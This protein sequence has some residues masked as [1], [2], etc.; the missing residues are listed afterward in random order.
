ML[1][2][3]LV[4]ALLGMCAS[5]ALAG[6]IT[7]NAPAPLP[8]N[9]GDT[10]MDARYRLSQTN[11]DQVIATSSNVT[12][13]TI[14]ETKNLGTANVLNGIEWSLQMQYTA[15]SGYVFTLSREGAVPP[16]NVSVVQWTAPYVY[17]QNPPV[18][19]LRNFNSIHLYCAAYAKN[20][21]TSAQFDVTN[22][23]FSGTGMTT[24]G[25]FVDMH[26]YLPPGQLV[27]QWL[28]ADTDLSLIDW[29]LTAKVKGTFE[30]TPPNNYDEQLKFDIKTKWVTPE[31]MTMSLM[32]LGGLLGLRR[33]RK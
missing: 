8:A 23:T 15:G 7:L 20:G 28:L 24:S 9:Q 14:V 26:A 2:K 1:K 12:Y 16:P 21:I 13:G 27:D 25:S 19:Q 10:V 18:S 33:N 22:L 6:I 4:I 11:W 5:S 32:A 30:G 29:T 17:E 3:S 31:P